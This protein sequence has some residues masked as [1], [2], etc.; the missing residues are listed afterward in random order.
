MVYYHKKKLTHLSSTAVVVKSNLCL[1]QN[2]RPLESKSVLDVAAENSWKEANS[3]W[4]G[5][6]RDLTA[7]GNVCM[8]PLHNIFCF[9]NSKIQYDE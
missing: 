8:V 7:S 4:Q 3:T 2:A 1:V 9:G 6:V 5:L